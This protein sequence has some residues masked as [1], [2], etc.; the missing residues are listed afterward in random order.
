MFQQFFANR[1]LNVLLGYF[2]PLRWFAD[3]QFCSK[4]IK[5]LSLVVQIVP[6]LR[7]KNTVFEFPSLP[8]KICKQKVK[9]VYSRM[10]FT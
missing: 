7:R 5:E 9:H 1:S 6:K 3:F 10:K 2:L 4:R 8:L